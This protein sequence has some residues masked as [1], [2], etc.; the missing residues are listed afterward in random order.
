M[1]DVPHETINIHPL[2]FFSPPNLTRAHL[3]VFIPS[4]SLAVMLEN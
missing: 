1:H 3:P 2:M 4:P